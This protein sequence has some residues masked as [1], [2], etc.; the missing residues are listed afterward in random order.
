MGKNKVI[1][2]WII[3]ALTIEIG[4]F[5]FFNFV[6]SKG[7]SI[8]GEEIINVNSKPD[9]FAS[10]SLPKDIKNFNSSYSGRYIS[11]YSS[12]NLYILD[13]RDGSK[14]QIEPTKGTAICYSKWFPDVNRMLL[15]ERKQNK[16]NF[17]YYDANKN[18]KIEM[19]DYDVKP[20]QLSLNS[21]TDEIEK[22]SISTKNTRM[23][24]KVKTSSGQSKFYAINIQSQLEQL[25]NISTNTTTFDMFPLDGNVIYSS[26]GK[27]R[28]SGYKQPLT[29]DISSNMNVLGIDY[30][31]KVYAGI[32][33]GDEISSI[34]SFNIDKGD[35]KDK[36][37]INLPFNTSPKNIRVLSVGGVFVIDSKDNKVIDIIN[38]KSTSYKGDFMSV[39]KG[40][41][42]SLKDNKLI[43]TSIK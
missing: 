23:T 37:I 21:K 12:T 1:F 20:L 42:Y 24:F 7:L 26:S 3:C 11:Y 34:C 10:I 17:Y 41:I 38:N 30:D 2:L 8:S 4:I 18:S 33:S 5:G 14:K 6:Y 36:K 19:Q 16:I 40:G 13:T 39:F 43:K 31:N 35:V 29:L 22:I 15:C 25:S 9:T 27:L 28:Q 32:F